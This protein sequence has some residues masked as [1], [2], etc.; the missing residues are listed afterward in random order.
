MKLSWKKKIIDK[1]IFKQ[2]L[3]PYIFGIFLVSAILVSTILYEAADFII[4]Y[5]MPIKDVI[6]LLFYM[7]PEVIV[8]TFP[9]AV[10]FATIYGLGNL[11][12]NNE[13]TALRM[14]G[15]S[16]YRLV[17]PLVVLGIFISGLTFFI[18]EEVVPAANQSAEN[19]ISIFRTGE[20]KTSIQED[21]IFEGPD[22]RIIFVGRFDE[23]E[24]KLE[25]IIIYILSPN[26]QG[27]PQITTAKKAAIVDSKLYL[28][29]VI[30]QNYDEDGKLLASSS[31]E[32]KSIELEHDIKGFLGEQRS[33]R[34]M[35]RSEIKELIEIFARSGHSYTEYLVD[36]HLKLAIAFIPLIFILIGTP[37]SLLETDSKAK[38]VVFTVIIVL[39]YYTLQSLCRSL[40]NN[41]ILSP[42][43][44]AWFPNV[45]FLLTGII[46][47]CWRSNRF[48]FIWKS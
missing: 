41:N 20:P 37:L 1:Y 44:A 9:I 23:Q 26:G 13:F 24:S 17:V 11:N 32:E 5:D 30:I 47:I 45:I 7:F 43:V 18:N 19:I 2:V 48:R 6:R 38:G 8:T 22:N 10:L 12:R 34:E 4:L 28:K 15:I 33:P 35:S 40:G 39:F 14:G 46:L 31:R 3:Y 29:N 27:Y 25:N 16:L 21:V 36:Y 42:L